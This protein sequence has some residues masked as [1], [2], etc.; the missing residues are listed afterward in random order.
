MA[1][2]TSQIEKHFQMHSIYKRSKNVLD[3]E[4]M[5]SHELKN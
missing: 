5:N 4:E 2:A 3:L 1:L